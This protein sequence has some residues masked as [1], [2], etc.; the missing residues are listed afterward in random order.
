MAVTE[1]KF[2]I[3]NDMKHIAPILLPLFLL[4]ALSTGCQEKEM[5]APLPVSELKAY[6]GRNSAKVEFKVPADAKAGKIFYNQGS[7]DFFPVTDPAAIQSFIVRGLPEGENILRVV[8][9]SADSVFS[10]PRGVK[11]LV[12]GDSYL[13]GL[14]NRMLKDQKFVSSSSI[15]LTFGEATADETELRIFFTNTS[16]AKDSVILGNNKATA[17]VED[18]DLGKDY[19]YCSVFKPEDSF[20]GE[21]ATDKVDIPEFF[22]KKLW[23][24]IWRIESSSGEDPQMNAANLIDNEVNSVWRP[25]GG[26]GP[27]W[28]TVDMQGPKLYDGFIVE[29]AQ[30]LNGGG[31]SKRYRFESSEDG[32]VW[33]VV[34]EGRLKAFAYR[35]KIVFK[36]SVLSRYFRI[37]VLDAYDDALPQLAELDLFNDSETSGVNGLEIPA[38][39]NAQPPFRGDGSDR[40]PA[41]G[42]GRMQRLT[43]W[44]HNDAAYIS[45]DTAIGSFNLFSCAIWGCSDVTNGKIH[46]SLHLLPGRYVLKVEMGGT[47]NV[48]CTDAFGIVTKAK[49]LPDF[50]NVATDPDVVGIEDLDAHTH[51][52]VSIPFV[53]ESETDVAIGVV[54]NT[55]NIFPT[56][57]WSD[58]NINSFVVEGE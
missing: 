51:M 17:F 52:L 28:I 53:L 8:T 36:E 14:S 4:V 23:K 30:E 18:I 27:H 21:Y 43:D 58:L 11:V 16:G 32:S 50:E 47:T 6:S 20:V 39:V 22:K 41:V 54:Y 35:Q 15:E 55:Y 49:D 24:N 42:A 1:V 26:S 10:D 37:T 29:Q 2:L 33:T 34:K 56:S 12:Y 38:L 40:F 25:Q 44:T 9:M 31:F 3:F 13:K 45:H 19:S 5:T 7:F 48:N 57:Y 46:Q